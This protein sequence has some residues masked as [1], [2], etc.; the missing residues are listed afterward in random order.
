MVILFAFPIEERFYDRNPLLSTPSKEFP[1]TLID[2]T[3]QN[4]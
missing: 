4:I 1:S 2:L 3:E